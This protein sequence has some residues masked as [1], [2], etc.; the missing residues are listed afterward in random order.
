[1][2]RST[3]SIKTL[4]VEC[5]TSNF[6]LR[7]GMKAAGGPEAEAIQTIAAGRMSGVNRLVAFIRIHPIAAIAAAVNPCM[8]VVLFVFVGMIIFQF[9]KG[10]VL[11]RSGRVVATRRVRPR[12]FWWTLAIQTFIVLCWGAWIVYGML[13]S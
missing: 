12:M 8:F 10:T 7:T 13:R 4:N 11:D 6:Q 1:M 3:F 9:A 5:P 2:L